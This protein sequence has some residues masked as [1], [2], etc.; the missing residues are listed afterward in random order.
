MC[1]YFKGKHQKQGSN[2]RPSRTEG[3]DWVEFRS[4]NLWQYQPGE[5]NTQSLGLDIQEDEHREGEVSGEVS[6]YFRVS[7]FHYL[8][9]FHKFLT[10]IFILQ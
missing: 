3:G 7:I 5:D 2:F 1:F 10:L 8:Y 6:C 4:Q 9:S